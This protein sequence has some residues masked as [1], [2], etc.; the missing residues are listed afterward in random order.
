MPDKNTFSLIVYA[1]RKNQDWVRKL[2]KTLDKRRPQVLIDATLVEIRKND[3]FNYDLEMV[4]GL[5]DLTPTSGQ[6]PT[7]R[8]STT[9]TSGRNQFAEFHVKSGKGVGFYADE[10][11]QALLTAVQTKNY[12][13]VL[14]KPKVLVND[15]EKGNIKTADTTY[16]V[17]KSSVP[18]AERQRR[19]SRTS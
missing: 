9:A 12:G 2:I 4:A 18:V 14:A 11:I 3:E 1:S 5:P 16:V 7:V 8:R 10:H 15:N 6:I 17:T 13:R 19:H